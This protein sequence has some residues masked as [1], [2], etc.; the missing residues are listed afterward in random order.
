[1]LAA[2][3]RILPRELDRGLGRLRAAGDE[4]RAL[5][6][7]AREPRYEIRELD[8][9]LV[10]EY[11]SA[12]IGDLPRLLGHGA[13]DA[14]VAVADVADDRTR[15]SIDVALALGIPEVN[16][17]GARDGRFPRRP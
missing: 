13:D 17:L 12:R 8:V 1:G 9:R 4:E 14:L 6:A 10:L 16:A 5:E 3:H 11:R 15:G 2:H 7:R